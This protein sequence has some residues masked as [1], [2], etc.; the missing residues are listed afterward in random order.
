MMIFKINV[1]T[2]IS[3]NVTFFIGQQKCFVYVRMC[4]VKERIIRGKPV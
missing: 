4:E 2:A 3:I 1:I